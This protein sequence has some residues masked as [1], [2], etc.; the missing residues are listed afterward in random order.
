MLCSCGGF[1]SSRTGCAAC[2]FSFCREDGEIST[3]P[4]N[5]ALDIACGCGPK[6]KCP[7]GSFLPSCFPEFY[8]VLRHTP[9]WITG[10]VPGCPGTVGEP[11]GEGMLREREFSPRWLVG[12]EQRFATTLPCT[13]GSSLYNCVDLTVTDHFH[14]IRSALWAPLQ[15]E[16]NPFLF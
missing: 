12:R 5:Y 16:A 10:W 14:S 8:L 7:V 4:L 11:E 6:D 1:I 3:N 9:R 13:P 2:R 15:L